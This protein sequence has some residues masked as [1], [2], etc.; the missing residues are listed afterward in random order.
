MLPRLLASATPLD[1]ALPTCLAEAQEQGELA[2]QPHP[3][4]VADCILATWEGAI[5]SAKV[6]QSAEVVWHC[7]DFLFSPLLPGA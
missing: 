3:A 2:P 1:P 7:I 4:E 6:M 5:F